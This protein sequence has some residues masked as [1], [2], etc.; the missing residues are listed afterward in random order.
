MALG[1]RQAALGTRGR[2]WA[3][4]VGEDWHSWPVALDPRSRGLIARKGG[5]FALG[6]EVWVKEKETHTKL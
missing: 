5:G 6:R 1:G 2:D 3:M 4:P